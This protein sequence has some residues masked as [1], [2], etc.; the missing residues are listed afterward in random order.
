[1]SVK[2]KLIEVIKYMT[3]NDEFKRLIEN[4]IR[5]G[6]YDLAVDVKTFASSVTG[7]INKGYDPEL[8]PLIPMIAKCPDPD[9]LQTMFILL[10]A[11]DEKER[12]TERDCV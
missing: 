4:D 3:K 10:L 2:E 8:V 5:K 9:M 12:A 1:M 7:M 6:N 11:A